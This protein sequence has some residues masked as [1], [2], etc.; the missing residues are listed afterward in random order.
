VASQIL[1]VEDSPTQALRTK[2]ELERCGFQVRVV[3]TGSGALRLAHTMPLAAILLD[4]ELPHISGHDICRFLKEDRRT[5]PIPVIML[6]HSA[7]EEDMRQSTAVGA[8]AHVV[9]GE[10]AIPAI[11]RI[12]HTL[13]LPATADKAAP[14]AGSRISIAPAAS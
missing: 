9:K 1:L 2:L 13:G 12:L 7:D 10:H 5:R 3:A 4:L 6:T 14:V 11:L 8:I